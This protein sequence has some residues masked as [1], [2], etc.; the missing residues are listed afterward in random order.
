MEKVRT[1]PP[2]FEAVN[3]GMADQSESAGQISETMAHLNE[4]T[5]NTLESL[6][7][8]KFAAEDLN[9]AALGLQ[10]Q[11]SRFEVV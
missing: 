6:R 5:Q 3:K 4:A 9:E 2:G 7:E 11:V 8:F 10:E 1:L